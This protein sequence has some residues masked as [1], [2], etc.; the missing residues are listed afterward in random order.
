[1]FRLLRLLA[2]QSTL[3]RPSPIKRHEMLLG[4]SVPSNHRK[5]RNSFHR[6]LR[7]ALCT[8][9]ALFIILPRTTAFF[10]TNVFKISFVVVACVDN[11]RLD[12]R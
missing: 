1:M 8:L 4:I 10:A 7:L 12:G 6:L 9:S 3:N 11:I 2:H 5:T